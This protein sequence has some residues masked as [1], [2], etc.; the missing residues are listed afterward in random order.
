MS[1]IRQKIKNLIMPTRGHWT[2]YYRMAQEAKWSDLHEVCAT[3]DSD[4]LEE[5]LLSGKYEFVDFKDPDWGD[6]APLHWCCMKGKSMKH[7]L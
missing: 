4:L 1:I 3:G 5:M 6:R 7:F 2:R